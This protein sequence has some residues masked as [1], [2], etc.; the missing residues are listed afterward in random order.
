[1]GEVANLT[2]GRTPPRGESRFWTNDLTRPFCT[3]ADMPEGGGRFTPVREGVTEAAEKE[4]KAKR[5]AAG[6]LLMSFKLTIGRVAFPSEDVFPNE[7][8]VH[9]Q[10]PDN[11]PVTKEYLALWLSSQDLTEGSGRAVKGKTLNGKSL[12]AIPVVYPPLS[13]QRRI[14]GLM[15][16]LDNHVKRLLVEAEALERLVADYREAQFD[17]WRAKA[18]RVAFGAITEDARRPLVVQPDGW[19]SEIGVRSHGRGVFGKESRTGAALGSKKMYM[20]QAGDLVLNIVFAWERAVAVVPDAFDGWASSHRFPTYRRVDG[21]S[22]NFLREFFLSSWG[23][24]EIGLASPGG[25]GRNRTLGR[26]ALDSIPVPKIPP[27]EEADFL[28]IIGKMERM[29]AALREEHD[30]ARD[31]RQA[32]LQALLSDRVRLPSSYDNWLGVAS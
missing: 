9:I 32:I 5:V 29:T 20:V 21:G 2:I 4:G 30:S 17:R 12:K 1:M 23:N 11:G 19:Y 31:S 8:I 13:V 26:E 16:H 22:V 27:H 25:A 14:V 6:S 15:E 18:K 3:I 10:P 28:D 7:A 24:Q